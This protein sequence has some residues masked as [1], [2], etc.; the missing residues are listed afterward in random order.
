VVELALYMAKK[1]NLLIIIN[2]F[3]SPYKQVLN[4]YNF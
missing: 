2:K 3:G 4:K 1:P